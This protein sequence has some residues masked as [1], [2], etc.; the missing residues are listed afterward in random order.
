ML[1]N[2]TAK[3][4]RSVCQISRPLKIAVFHLKGSSKF[5]EHFLLIFFKPSRFSNLPEVGHIKVYKSVNNI[6]RAVPFLS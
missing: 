3:R 6:L 1:A 2:D 5:I 4:A